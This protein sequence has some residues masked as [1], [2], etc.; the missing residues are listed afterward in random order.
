MSSSSLSIKRSPFRFFANRRRLL[1]FGGLAAAVVLL[2]GCTVFGDGTFAVGTG[3]TQASPGTYQSTGG[4][5]C[6]WQRTT[7]LS[8]SE[9]SIIANSF[10]NGP[11]VVTILPSDG[12][13][14]SQGCGLWTLLPSSGP[15]ATSFGDGGYAIGIAI[16]P[17]TYSAPGGANCYWEQDSDFLDAGSSII[18]NDL[19]SGPVTV[20]LAP[21]A[22]RFYV[23]GCGTWTQGTVTPVGDSCTATMSNSNPSDYTDDTVNITSNVADAPVLIDKYYDTLTSTDSGETNSGGSAS[24]TFDDSGA[25]LGYTVQVDVSINSGQAICSTSFTPQ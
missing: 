23:Q 3:N 9:G 2:S 15:E 4:S 8:G 17:G 11:D 24:I 13:F 5:E 7:D 10:L 19:P 20:T 16:A 25:T 14:Q 6:Y 1:T 18:S 22:A 21:N 12:G